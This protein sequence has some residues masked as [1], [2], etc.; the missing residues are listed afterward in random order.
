MADRYITVDFTGRRQFTLIET[1]SSR[2]SDYIWNDSKGL[3]NVYRETIDFGKVESVR[4]WYN[5]LPKGQEAQCVIG[6]V[7]ALPMV[8]CTVRN[9]TVSVNGMSVVLPVEMHSGSYLEFNAAGSCM[10]YGAK[11][12]LIT[13]V[14][15]ENEIPLL[16]TGKNEIGFSCSAANGPAPRVKLTVISH[17]QPL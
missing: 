2:W 5:N 4:I 9:P 11:G 1:E 17:G 16:S 6:P 12:E 7:K 14:S 13:R 15:P 8:A 10:L 3:Y